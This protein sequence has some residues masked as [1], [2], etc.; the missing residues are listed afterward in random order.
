MAAASVPALLKVSRAACYRIAVYGGVSEFRTITKLT[1]ARDDVTEQVT[2][3][4]TMAMY[5]Q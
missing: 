1:I 5:L 3:V 2:E 4:G